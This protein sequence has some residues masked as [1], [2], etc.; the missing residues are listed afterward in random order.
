MG[1][2][3]GTRT[4]PSFGHSFVSSMKV[5]I[6]MNLTVFLSSPMTAVNPKGMINLKDFTPDNE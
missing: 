6:D 3:L 5:C 1:R 2:Q 4:R